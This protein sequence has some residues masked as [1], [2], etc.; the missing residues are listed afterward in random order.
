MR[1]WACLVV[2][3]FGC[4]HEPEGR[5]ECD[6]LDESHC[7]L[8]FPTDYY[9]VGNQISI[10]V[11]AMPKHREGKPIDPGNFKPAGWSTVTQIYFAMDG[12]K[13][14]GTAQGSKSI[15]QSILPT[16]KT[17]IIDAQ[18]GA[19]HPHWVEFDYLSQDSGWPTVALRVAKPLEYGRRY[20]VAVRDLIGE[21]GAVMP[22]TRGF[23]ALRDGTT[24][25]VVG[26]EDRRGHFES[27]VFPVLARA[28]VDR[29]TVQLAWDFTTTP[30][31]PV[32]KPLLTARA[33]LMALIGD[34]GPEYTIFKVDTDV[35]GPGGNIA[36]KVWGNAKVPNFLEPKDKDGIK[37]LHLGSDG[38][39][40]PV[41]T[42][43]V[44]FAIQIPR[45]ALTSLSKSSVVQY[46]H[47]FLGRKA[48]ADGGWMR[49][50]AN[51]HNFLVLQTDMEGMN[52]EAGITWFQVLP[53]DASLTPHLSGWP[54][55]GIMNHIALQRMMKGRFL[56]DT[57]PR[58][59]KLGQPYY[60]PAKMYYHGN[61]QGGT[62]GNI[63]IS[64]STDITRALLGEP[65]V[66]FAFLV[67]RATQCETL[68]PIIE[69]GYP[70]KRDMQV[71][72]GLVQSAFDRFEPAAFIARATK[73]PPAGLPLHQLLI[74]IA[75]EDKQV[76]NDVST[77][78]ARVVGAKLLNP[79]LRP[80]WGLTTV[81][82][83]TMESAVVE[84]DYGLAENPTPNRPISN[85]DDPH[86]WVRKDPVAQDQGMHFFDTGLIQ[87]FCGGPCKRPH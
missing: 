59:T 20:V 55:Q 60:D 79:A 22:P 56:A 13:L 8:P 63:V 66:A 54:F 64:M 73:N 21:N 85:V 29:S 49:T 33:K 48:E 72:L 24:P 81:D 83:P 68:G 14:D 37:K 12:V 19:L 16:T 25:E 5:I 65:G 50:W 41:G 39:P 75:K 28:G 7:M 86:D 52:E 58:Y 57:D 18:T 77:I 51:R 70:D 44:E 17:L 23:K 30:E 47:G 69:G 34:M 26:V 1:G 67:S 74:H 38:L 76:H 78:E 31:E 53:G 42:V 4:S 27:D 87:D 45:V 15:D 82:G 80:L 35:D 84:W 10:P 11:A 40:E 9:R 61:S 2:L 6:N 71:L 36:I 43:D 3:A 62:I 32:T 46:G